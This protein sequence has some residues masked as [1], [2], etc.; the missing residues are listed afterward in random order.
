[1][2]ACFDGLEQ[3]IP[4]LTFM[5][6]SYGA[7]NTNYP[8]K[9]L[10]MTIPTAKKL[11]FIGDSITDC[12][13]ERPIA[14]R[15]R[16]NALG[17][18]YVALVEALLTAQQHRHG[19]HIINMGIS[20]NT[21]RDLK[22]RWQRDVDELRPDIVSIMIGIN[23]VW[24]QVNRPG[25][26]YNHVQI[27][28]YRRNLNEL[29]L[30]A[31]ET[32][33]GVILMTPFFIEGNRQDPMRVLMDSYGAVVKELA[34]E[35]QLPVVD[36]QAAYNAALQHLHPMELAEDRVHPYLAGH[37]ILAQAFLKEFVLHWPLKSS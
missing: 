13:R 24:R 29:I 35:H 16:D 14:D 6:F 34:A 9:A 37:M 11:L 18:G 21:T 20:G 22:A 8:H 12:E 33:Q 19:Y 1:M 7:P 27:G 4:F 10:M 3:F 25:Q 36:T 30:A 31:K 2:V 15:P 23:D 28:E 32:A 26:T 5:T 17:I